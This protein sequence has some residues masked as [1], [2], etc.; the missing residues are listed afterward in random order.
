MS[1]SKEEVFNALDVLN[2]V[3]MEYEKFVNDC[4]K[5]KALSLGNVQHNCQIKDYCPSF[6]SDRDINVLNRA[7]LTK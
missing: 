7:F 2:K 6:L 3:G 4:S 5:C 1:K